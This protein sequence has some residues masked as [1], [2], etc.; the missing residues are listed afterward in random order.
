M[1]ACRARDDVLHVVK[2]SVF[3]D[4]KNMRVT[5]N[6]N[7]RWVLFEFRQHAAIVATRLTGDMGHPDV[8]SLAIES[9]VLWELI[10]DFVVVDVSKDSAKLIEAF[11]QRFR[12][13]LA[14][15]ACMPDL[16]TVFEKLEDSRI[17]VAVSV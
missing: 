9:Q 5:T 12:H 14:K 6:Q 2:A 11:H 16:V 1:V 4:V 13:V 3:F 8:H 17:Q 15:V 7:L 10:L